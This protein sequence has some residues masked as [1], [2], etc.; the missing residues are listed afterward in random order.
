MLSEFRPYG[1]ERSYFS[2][3]FII[4]ELC[5]RLH[6]HEDLLNRQLFLLFLCFMDQSL[7]CWLEVND[8]FITFLVI[9]WVEEFHYFGKSKEVSLLSVF[10]ISWASLNYKDRR[11]C[12]EATSIFFTTFIVLSEWEKNMQI[13]QNKDIH[14]ISILNLYKRNFIGSY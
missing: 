11:S 8:R 5:N 10:F 7:E 9:N 3:P 6:F 12:L 1:V 2:R 13:S 14:F 4:W